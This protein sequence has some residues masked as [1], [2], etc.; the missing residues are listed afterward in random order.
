MRADGLDALVENGVIALEQDDAHD[1]RCIHC[2]RLDESWTA[3]HSGSFLN[4]LLRI[5][6]KDNK[7]NE[8]D[9]AH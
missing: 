7:D 2:T 1:L 3:R 6:K 9:A 8:A 5:F 4:R